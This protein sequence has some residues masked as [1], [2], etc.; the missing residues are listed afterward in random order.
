LAGRLRPGLYVGRVV[1]PVRSGADVLGQVS[2]EVRSRK[3]DYLSAYR[4]MLRDLA[5][6]GGEIVMAAFAPSLGSFFLDPSAD[7]RTLY[8]RFAFLQSLVGGDQF[9]AAM[10]QILHSP[11]HEWRQEE[12]ERYPGQGLRMGS[13]AARE[14]TRP[15]PRVQL[16]AG[17]GPPQVRAVPRR[18]RMPRT[19]STLDNLPNR[20]IKH[21]LLEWLEISVLVSEALRERGE[22]HWSKRGSQEAEALAARLEAYLGE[23]LFREVGRLTGLP[24]A[25]QVLIKR[26]SYREVYQIHG[27]ATLAAKLA[28]AGGDMVYGAGRRDVASLYEYWVYLHLGKVLAGLSGGTFS[29][30]DLVEPTEDG[31]SL[32]LKRGRRSLLSGEVRRLGRTL[33]IEF[34]FNRTFR[35]GSQGS[36]SWTREMKP[37]CSIRIGP[38]PGS[39]GGFE[40]IWVHF[41]AKYRIERVVDAFGAPGTSE[42]DIEEEAEEQ[43]AQEPSGQAKR[44]DLLK[45]HAYRDAIRRSAGAYVIFPG[46][47]NPEEFR[48]YAEVLPG[49]GAFP[50][51]PT[52]SGQ[53]VGVELLRRFLDDIL[54]HTASQLSQHERARFWVREAQS[55]R[56]WTERTLTA[57]GFLATPPADTRVLLGYVRTE[58][59]M[60]WIKTTGL[61]NL[62]AGERRGAVGIDGQEVS[63]DLV[64]LYG[65]GIPAPEIWRRSGPP[66]VWGPQRM[67]DSGYPSP[68]PQGY[69]CLPILEAAAGSLPPGLTNELVM[70]IQEGCRPG[71]IGAPAVVTWWNLATAEMD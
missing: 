71:A 57:Q 18:L 43:D 4:W 31:L 60:G 69:L 56:W 41:D 50:L 7:A 3:L 40:E 46:R 38:A 36:P 8:Q 62:R 24:M 9:D 54:T 30:E 21:A 47:E 11:F 45:M 53:V 59:H 51:R 64:V 23:E 68:S 27:L 48:E 5:E 42:I 32:A 20:M 29:L 26:E 34:W 17:V 67:R 19:E 63:A 22:R 44:A 35:A 33:R 1:T 12:E 49:L 25:N 6:A 55:E 66:E 37:D 16:P 15:G 39:V 14:L 2:F 52:G 28:W 13:G 58:A 70:A 61:Y 10:G 65:G